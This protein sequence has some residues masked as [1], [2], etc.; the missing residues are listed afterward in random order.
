M[1][2]IQ[3]AIIFSR[4]FTPMRGCNL[5]RP[6]KLAMLCQYARRPS[7]L[8]VSHELNS[9]TIATMNPAREADLLTAYHANFSHKSTAASGR[10]T[11]LNVIAL[12][13]G[14]AVMRRVLGV[15]FC[16]PARTRSDQH[17]VQTVRLPSN[18][19]PRAP[20]VPQASCADMRC[21]AARMSAD[22]VRQPRRTSVLSFR[23]YRD[24]PPRAP[25]EI[26]SAKVLPKCFQSAFLLIQVY[27]SLFFLSIPSQ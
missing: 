14:H 15:V 22:G 5:L 27:R 20:Q 7:K 9:A 16:F 19:E 8:H 3:S 25:Q 13:V 2:G 24:S 23:R 6:T 4:H 18:H 21:E 11:H 1:S 26:Q 12:C 10:Y 17:A